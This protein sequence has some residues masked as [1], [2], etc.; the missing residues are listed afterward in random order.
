MVPDEKI[1]HHSY[2]AVNPMS[3]SGDWPGKRWPQAAQYVMK[4]INYSV[5][6]I[7]TV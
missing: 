5:I 2:L 3:Y 1:H 4:V 6:V 7:R